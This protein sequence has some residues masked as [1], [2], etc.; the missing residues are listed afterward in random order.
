MTAVEARSVEATLQHYGQLT[1]TALATYLPDSEPRAHLWDLVATYPARGGKAIRPSLCLATCGAFG[2]ELDECLP[3]AVAIELLHNAFLVHDDIEDESELRRGEPT[4]HATHGVALALN[5]G[6]ALALLA[7]A[8]LRDNRERIGS[9]MAAKVADEFERMA[10]HTVEGQA[11]ELGWRRDATT[12]LG[13]DD[14]LDLILRKTCWY[15]T[16]HP[17]RV[18]ALIGSWE[19][20]DL[21]PLVRFGFY[22]GAAFQIQDDL[23]N[24]VGDPARYGK[25]P[26]GDL[27]EGKRTLMLIHL[28]SV[29]GARERRWLDSVLARPRAE[30]TAADVEQLLELLRRHGSIEFAREFAKGIAS[31]AEGAFEDAFAAVPESPDRSFIHDLIPWMLDRDA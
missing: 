20:A 4:L 14:Y 18:G 27:Y 1:A 17:M 28:L 6:D 3:S 25:E 13:P 23:L 16:I 15:T 9:R 19:R 29:A 11:M 22:L 7:G 8:P 5:A 2:G 24:L 30:R 12:G 10:R 31:A 21:D 26:C